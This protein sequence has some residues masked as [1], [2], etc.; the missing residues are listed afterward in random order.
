MVAG[1]LTLV[2]ML[3]AMVLRGHAGAW[4]GAVLGQN[5]PKSRDEKKAL[6]EGHCEGLG[7]SCTPK[8]T[9]HDVLRNAECRGSYNDGEAVGDAL[10]EQ[11]G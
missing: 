10:R 6:R 1:W 8:G 7:D 5:V 4:H 3:C 11:P 2:G 9:F